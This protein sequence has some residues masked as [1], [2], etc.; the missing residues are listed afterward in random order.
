MKH[1]MA[2][3]VKFLMVA[4]ILEI[5]LGLLTDLAFS[6]ILIVSLAVTLIA[7]IIGDLLILRFSNNTVST[8]SDAI[9]SFITIYGFSLM[10]NY[11]D[12][13][14]L[15][16]VICAVVLG[17]GEWFYHKYIVKKEVVKS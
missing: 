4:I 17:I 12:I 7:Y 8:I 2:L 13:E 5:A 9:L 1:V 15:D 16:A 11:R 3:L 14:L 6:Q 10:E